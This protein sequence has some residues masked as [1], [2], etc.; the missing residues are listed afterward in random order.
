VNFRRLY[1]FL[2][3]GLLQPSFLLLALPVCMQMVKLPTEL[4]FFSP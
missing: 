4:H 2:S 3:F 1:I